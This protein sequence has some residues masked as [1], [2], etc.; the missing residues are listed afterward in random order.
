M[1]SVDPEKRAGQT[2]NKTPYGSGGKT[3]FAR[4]QRGESYARASFGPEQLVLETVQ[5]VSLFA[6][7]SLRKPLRPRKNKQ[8]NDKKRMSRKK[9][10]LATCKSHENSVRV[11]NRFFFFFENP[12]PIDCPS[13]VVDHGARCS[14]LPV[15][16]LTNAP[17]KKRPLFFEN[18]QSCC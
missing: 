16:R 2:E 15:S 1:T 14:I 10:V 18:K 12:N 9:N 13:N 11:F 7:L 5:S 3:E 6:R 8:N 4:G 17:N